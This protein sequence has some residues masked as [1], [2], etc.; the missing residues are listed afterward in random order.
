[1]NYNITIKTKRLRLSMMRINQ[2]EASL[3]RQFDFAI[4]KINFSI[5]SQSFKPFIFNVF[6]GFFVG[7]DVIKD[8]GINRVETPFKLVE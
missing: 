2:H 5:N 6:I 1:M 8:Q 4:I 7:G 3:F